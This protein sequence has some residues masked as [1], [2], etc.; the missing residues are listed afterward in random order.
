MENSPLR[1]HL[2]PEEIARRQRWVA[3]GVT[4][5][6]LLLIVTWA[7]TLPARIGQS[8]GRGGSGW[9]AIFG[10]MPPTKFVDTEILTDTATQT[11]NN[12]EILTAIQEVLKNS[13]IASTTPAATT[14]PL[15]ISA[16]TTPNKK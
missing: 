7:M 16:T 10:E 13:A 8:S 2:H 3:V 12:T 1:P 5:L 15:I 6:T 11:K 14:T 9:R 4:V